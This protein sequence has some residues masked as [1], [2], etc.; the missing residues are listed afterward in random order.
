MD[1]LVVQVEQELV[2]QPLD[3]LVRAHTLLQILILASPVN[4]VIHHDSIHLVV[5]VCLENGLFD[6]DTDVG[7]VAERAARG[8]DLSEFVFD[9]EGF[10]GFACELGEGISKGRS[11]K[12][13]FEPGRARCIARFE[14][15]EK[16]AHTAE[17]AEKRLRS[18]AVVGQAPSSAQA[19]ALRGR[20][21]PLVRR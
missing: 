16:V 3:I 6:A 21:S 5:L 2:V 11:I 18:N 15:C 14:R 4:G 10:A 13:D 19:C 8:A 20:P 9:A 1:S 12:R 17:V 7:L